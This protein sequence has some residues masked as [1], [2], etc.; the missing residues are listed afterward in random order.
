MNRV[1]ILT[2]LVVLAGC[3]PSLRAASYFKAH[4]DQAIQVLADCTAVTYRGAECENARTAEAHIESD[5]RLNL[6]KNSF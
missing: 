5:T 3:S 4:P 6:H 1:V 2:A